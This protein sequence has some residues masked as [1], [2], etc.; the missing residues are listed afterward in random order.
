MVVYEPIRPN[1]A[2]GKTMV[3]NLATRG[4]VLQTLK[5]YGSFEA[6]DERMRSYG[7]SSSR[8]ADINDLWKRGIEEREK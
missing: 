1:D 5:K 4:I 6:Q 8:V 2:F 7:F 3:S